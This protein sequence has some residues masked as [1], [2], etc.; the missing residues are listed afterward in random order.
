MIPAFAVISSKIKLPLFTITVIVLAVYLAIQILLFFPSQETNK[1]LLDSTQTWP[2][3]KNK[4]IQDVE[5]YGY[6]SMRESKEL[7]DMI[8]HSNDQYYLKKMKEK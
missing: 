7:Q 5:S 2:E 4:I 3:Y 8:Q 6:Y 1:D